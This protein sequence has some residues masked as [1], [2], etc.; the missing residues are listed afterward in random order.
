M[1]K[2]LAS[3]R[4]TIWAN[5]GVFAALWASDAYGFPTYATL[6]KRCF[7]FILFFFFFSPTQI[8]A[9]VR[10]RKLKFET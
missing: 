8:S 4:T 1:D 6:S 9:L 5:T 10:A 3:Y 7:V 2:Y